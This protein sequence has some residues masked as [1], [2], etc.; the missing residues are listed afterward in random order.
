VNKP[1]QWMHVLFTPKY[2]MAVGDISQHPA[3]PRAQYTP[4]EKRKLKGH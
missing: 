4:E 3:H 2:R 1:F